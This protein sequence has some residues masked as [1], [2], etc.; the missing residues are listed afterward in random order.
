MPPKQPSRPLAI[1]P[2]Q[3]RPRPARL[4][5]DAPAG[6]GQS[7]KRKFPVAH[8]LLADDGSYDRAAIVRRANYEVRR[9]PRVGLEW[10]RVHCLTYVWRQAGPALRDVFL[11][12][13]FAPVKNR[14][15]PRLRTPSARKTADGRRFGRGPRTEKW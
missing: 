15:V 11:G 3:Y 7:Q 12:Y 10:D 14:K 4:I 5:F 13:P 8:Q 9:A 6:Q 1:D 2:R